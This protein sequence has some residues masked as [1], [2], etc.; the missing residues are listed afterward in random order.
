MSNILWT[1]LAKLPGVGPKTLIKLYKSFPDLEFEDLK[2]SNSSLILN[3]IKYSKIVDT[4]LD[5]EYMKSAFQKTELQIIDYKKSGV[6]VISIGDKRYPDILRQIEDPPSVL[7]CR[8]N[9]D[10]LEIPKKVAIVGTRRA[11][12]KGKNAA[13]KIAAAFTKLNYVIVSGLAFGID[14]AGHIGA[15]ESNGVT[16]AV[17]PGGVDLN[18]VYPAKNK[19]LAEEIVKNKGL[20]ISEYPPGCKPQ[21]SAF[22]QRDRIQS[23][24]SLGVCP[25]QTDVS[26]GTQH[27]IKFTQKQKRILFCPIPSED[28]HI[29]M[30]VY[31]G[32]HNLI[33]EKKVLILNDK[34]DYKKLD[35]IMTELLNINSSINIEAEA[36]K[37][38]N[39]HIIN[40]KKMYEESDPQLSIFNL[41]NYKELDDDSTSKLNYTVEQYCKVCH[42]FKIDI[43]D[44][45]ELL[46]KN[47][48]K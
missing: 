12:P 42:E 34:E 40:N 1:T 30:P 20:L 6:E 13:A 23:G 8:G 44:A 28:G 39:I 29:E 31:R 24:L 10:A 5:K 43:T 26:G 35:K 7:Y 15:L 18:S 14:T 11:T 37:K 47:W 4:M 41:G 17:L 3:T 45:I 32:I 38:S 33:N 22:V 48:I 27:T 25:V 21:K 36:N 2:E 19:A 9:L 46:K 16:I